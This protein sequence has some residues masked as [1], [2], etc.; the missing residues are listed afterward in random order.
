MERSEPSLVPEWLK[1]ASGSALASPQPAFF[2]EDGGNT[3]SSRCRAT[4]Q[5]AGGHSDYDSPRGPVSSDRSLFPVGRRSHGSNCSNALDRSGIDRDNHIQGRLHPSLTRSGSSKRSYVTPD[6]E[7]EWDGYRADVNRDRDWV[8]DGERSIWPRELDVLSATSSDERKREKDRT[9]NEKLRLTVPGKPGTYDSDAKLWRSQPMGLSPRMSDNN[10]WKTNECVTIS[11]PMPSSS[12]GLVTSMQKAVFERNF[13]SLGIDDKP[14]GLIVSSG[15]SPVASPRPLW[16]SPSRLDLGRASSP[17][18]P[19]GMGGPPVTSL[20]VN[21]AHGGGDLWNSVL[22]EVPVLNDNLQNISLG[23]ALPSSSSGIMPSAIPSVPV[24]AM[25]ATVLNMAEALTQAPP[26]VRTPPQSSA[27]SQRLEELAIKQSR[28]L[29]PMTPSLP[30]TMILNDKTKSKAVRAV[31]GTVSTAKLNQL[32]GTLQLNPS[33]RTSNTSRPDTV[34]HSQGKLLVLKASKDGG[35]LST[36]A[37]KPEGSNPTQ[38]SAH[39]SIGGTATTLSASFLS[40]P[41]HTGVIGQNKRSLVDR[42]VV[43]QPGTGGFDALAGV[44]TK[45]SVEDK[46]PSLQAQ[47]RSD[48]FNTLRR[49]AA[50]NGSTSNILKSDSLQVDSV[51]MAS[52]EAVI[53]E[54]AGISNHAS[55]SE[56]STFSE[57][58]PSADCISQIHS[59]GGTEHSQRKGS[60]LGEAVCIENNTSNSKCTEE[61]LSV[62]SE[63]EEAAFMR[64]LGWEENAEGSELTEEEIN[65]FYQMRERR[66]SLNSQSLPDVRMEP[67]IS[68]LGIPSF[69]MSSSESDSDD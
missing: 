69:G 30:K 1:G 21:G 63:E 17:G 57:I 62:D 40:I 3:A 14:G 45:D 48:F 28:Q 51:V 27:E 53:P 36:T 64:S 5:V 67:S 41:G 39:G 7:K 42:R 33:N 44:R 24:P 29:I 26:R 43:S 54:K 6:R 12:G 38:L 56:I 23:N 50:G 49:K 8:P 52:R 20:S 32:P 16:Q 10:A 11:L 46:R 34:K 35:I 13:P 47:N 60:I 59:N 25:T 18:L 66:K 61:R 31:D 22:A 2:Q 37:L 58:S 15:S 55:E 68:S 65:S 4:Q 19:G 9:E